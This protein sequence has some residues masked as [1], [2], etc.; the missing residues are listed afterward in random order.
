MNKVV[1]VILFFSSR[2]IITHPIRNFRSNPSSTGVVRKHWYSV[3]MNKSK[4][5]FVFVFLPQKCVLT[6]RHIFLKLLRTSSSS[7]GY[8]SFQKYKCFAIHWNLVKAKVP[9]KGA[10]TLFLITTNFR[11]AHILVHILQRKLDEKSQ[12]LC[13]K[14]VKCDECWHCVKVQM[15][16]IYISVSL[17]QF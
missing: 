14:N 9:G 4:T 10:S 11:S 3:G 1:P 2:Q 15:A 6:N 5:F 12:S 8:T 17:L 16:K 13:T 7:F